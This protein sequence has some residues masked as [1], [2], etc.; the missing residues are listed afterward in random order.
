MYVDIYK[1]ANSLTER[2][3]APLNNRQKDTNRH[4]SRGYARS[5]ECKGF[6]HPQLLGKC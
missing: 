1:E 4:F 6:Q 5:Q 3:T 2:Q